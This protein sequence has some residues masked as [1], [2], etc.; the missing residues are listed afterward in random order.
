MM[1][2]FADR[3]EKIKKDGVYR[4]LKRSSVCGADIEIDGARY[5]NFAS[6]DYLG[7]SGRVDWQ[8][9]FLQSVLNGG[10]KGFLMGLRFVAASRLQFGGVFRFR[11]LY[12]ERIFG[13][14][15]IAKVVPAI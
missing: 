10:E 11:V 9:E 7:I 15:R 12:G 3:L 6:N 8:R 13:Y 1:R 14:I 4:S 2:N 5:A